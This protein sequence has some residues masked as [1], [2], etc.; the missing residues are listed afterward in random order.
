[1][2]AQAIWAVTK[3]VLLLALLL[4]SLA[5]I[6]S[7][8]SLPRS[9]PVNFA[10]AA[11]VYVGGSRLL[12]RYY[13]HW[14]VKHYVSKEAVL[15]YGAGGAGIQLASAL[16][17][18]REFYPVGF[19]DDDPTLWGSTIKG[20]PISSVYEV[21]QLV[22]NFGIKHILLAVPRSTNKQRRQML[23]HLDGVNVHVQTIPSMP[24]LLEGKASIEQLREVHI[25]ELLGRDPVPA[26]PSLMSKCIFD[27]V[28]MVTGAGGSIGS[29]LC[30]Q[31]I[32]Q[33]PKALL[34]FECSE[35]ALYQIHQELKAAMLQLPEI[36]QRLFIRY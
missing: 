24:E 1:M 8:D 9:V 30:R 15:I 20:L 18:G 14:A 23:E 3:G 28:V 16:S 11:L 17:D 25:E 36:K 35:Y 10:L 7:L 33:C 31:V 22:D 4:W 6:F 26:L 21:E 12:I 34:L 13:Y 5:Y 32:Q 2:G 19:I 27:K 29:E